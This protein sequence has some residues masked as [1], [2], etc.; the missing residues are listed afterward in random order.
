MTPQTAAHQASLSMGFSRQEFQNR[1]PFPSPGDLL[2]P[3]IKPCSSTL[4]ET[5]LPSEPPGKPVE[6]GELDK[7]T[8]QRVIIPVQPC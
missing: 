5:S 7:E 2:N 3:G 8:S 6:R 4:Q 1:L